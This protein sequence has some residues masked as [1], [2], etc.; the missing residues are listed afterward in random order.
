MFPD[1][2][3][4]FFAVVVAVSLVGA[5]HSGLY[6]FD[7]TAEEVHFE[8]GCKSTNTISMSSYNEQG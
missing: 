4:T 8:G 5:H 3:T 1:H 6:I 2:A 7:A